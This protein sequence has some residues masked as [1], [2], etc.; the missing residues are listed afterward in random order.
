MV[1]YAEVTRTYADAAQD[2]KLRWAEID[3]VAWLRPVAPWLSGKTILDVGAGTG[4]LAEHLSQTS[5][6]IAVEPVAGL[7]L[8]DLPRVTDT[9][10]NLR[11][12]R[13]RFDL[14]LCLGVLHHLTPQD[15]LRAMARLASLTRTGGKIIIAARH[16]PIHMPVWPV[17][18]ATLIAPTLTRLKLS[19][20]PALQPLNRAKSVRFTWLVFE[21][22]H[23]TSVR[24]ASAMM[25][26]N[27][28][29]QDKR[30]R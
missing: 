28:L 4:R 19:R 7:W 21:K 2:L 8:S 20:R 16:G 24:S 12:V 29:P 3:L 23:S 11:K 17:R 27:W 30:K 14:V 1:G 18:A 9:L 10:P 13:G 25:Q 5:R 6:V 15:Q 22:S 26:Q